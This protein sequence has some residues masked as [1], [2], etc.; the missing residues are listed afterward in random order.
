MPELCVDEYKLK[1][2]NITM[3]IAY[4]R[5]SLTWSELFPRY[6]DVDKR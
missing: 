3:P 2:S 5:T 1:I 6:F 4:I